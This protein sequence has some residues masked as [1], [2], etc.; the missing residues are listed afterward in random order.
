[1]RQSAYSLL[2]MNQRRST[3]KVSPMQR[4]TLNPPDSAAVVLFATNYGRP[5]VS[6]V[7]KISLNFFSDHLVYF[8]LPPTHAYP[9]YPVGNS[10]A[11]ILEHELTLS[12][13]PRMTL[14]SLCPTSTQ[15]MPLSFICSALISPVN[16]PLGLSKTFCAATS[17]SL[18]R[19]SRAS[20]R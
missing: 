11:R 10:S 19:C 18:R 5:L 13:S 1:M 12:S 9:L 8:N 20:K 15:P 14:R 4:I 3:S 17:I 2:T 6:S 16:A 7:P